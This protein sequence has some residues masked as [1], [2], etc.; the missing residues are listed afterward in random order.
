MRHLPRPG[1]SSGL[2]TVS[3]TLPSDGHP[4]QGHYLSD[5][6]Q[7]RWRRQREAVAAR[8]PPHEGV[9]RRAKPLRCLALTPCPLS[10]KLGE[11]EN[12]P[13]RPVGPGVLQEAGHLM[14]QRVK[15]SPKSHA[16]VSVRSDPLAQFLG[17]GAGGEG[18]PFSQFLG[19]LWGARG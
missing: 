12:R 7:Y 13:G 9:R 2:R 11:G 3:E 18:E 14:P 4:W 8:T 16:P 15:N 17:E 5:L 1:R 10:Q 6:S 19:D